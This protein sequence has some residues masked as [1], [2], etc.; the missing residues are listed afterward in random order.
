[1]NK[2]CSKHGFR[3]SESSQCNI[4]SGECT[5]TTPMEKTIRNEK[6]WAKKCLLDLKTD[7]LE[8]KY[9]TTDPDSSA[10]RSA[11]D[12]HT[13]KS[14]KLTLNF[15]LTQGILEKIKESTLKG[16]L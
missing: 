5:S 13:E 16:G 3:S 15:R 6:E 2:L 10:Y 7:D 11:I 12:L 1:M 14:V 8:V 9:I 4:V